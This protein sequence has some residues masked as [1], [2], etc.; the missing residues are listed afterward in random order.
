MSPNT[1]AKIHARSKEERTHVLFPDPPQLLG[2]DVSR[3]SSGEI[4]PLHPETP[5]QNPAHHLPSNTAKQRH[6]GSCMLSTDKVAW[7]RYTEGL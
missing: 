2:D 4:P 7:S 3:I 1:E 6:L 5:F